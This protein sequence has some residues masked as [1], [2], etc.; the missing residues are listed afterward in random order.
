VDRYTQETKLWLE[1]RFRKCDE[2]GIYFAH[3]PIYGFRKGHSDPGL[4]DKYIRTCQ[5]MKALSHMKFDSLLD[6]GG[7]EGY[8]AYIAKQIFGVNVKASDLSEEACLRAREIFHVDSDPADIHELPYA[9]SEFDIVLCSETLEHVTD[10]QGAIGE[11]LRVAAKAVVITVPHEDRAVIESN[12]EK[13][14]PHAHI[15]SFTLDSL[16][17]LKPQG[18][19]IISKRMGCRLLLFLSGYLIE[20]H[21]RPRWDGITRYPK[22]FVETC[23]V[24]LLKR[25]YG[26]KVASLAINL[27][28][29]I[30]HFSSYCFMLF[31]VLK[32]KG[33]YYPK[34]RQRVSAQQIV[35]FAVSY[36][37][38]DRK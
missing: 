5:I 35:N 29:L 14:I 22:S 37:Y 19:E 31:V 27:D 18:Y 15:H 32:D 24:P 1:E 23:F 38:L 21:P 16:N 11:L 10:Y 7:A 25:M 9:D 17:F 33:C 26:R 28:E 6:V 34:E 36:H 2:Q 30:C 13:R 12:I 3:Q 4:M 8:T 20:P